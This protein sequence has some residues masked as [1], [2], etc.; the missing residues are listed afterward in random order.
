M[1][2]DSMRWGEAQARGGGEVGRGLWGKE[3]VLGALSGELRVLGAL[4]GEVFWVS[5]WESAE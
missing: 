3:R 4:S 1:L 2:L 5:C